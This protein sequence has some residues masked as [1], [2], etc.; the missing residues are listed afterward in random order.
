MLINNYGTIK[1]DHD[2]LMVSRGLNVCNQIPIGQLHIFRMV[3]HHAKMI[4]ET[5]K[6]LDQTGLKFKT[7]DGLLFRV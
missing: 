4:A 6:D 3:V 7:T 1:R 5:V 2:V